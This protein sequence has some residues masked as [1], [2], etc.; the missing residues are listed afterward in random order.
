MVEAVIWKLE[1]IF[2][3]VS[4]DRH[5]AAGKVLSYLQS[6]PA[7]PFVDEA[8]RLLFLKGTDSHDYKYSSA[9]LEDYLGLSQEWRDRYLAAS[10]F[11]LRGSGTRDNDLVQRVRAA[12]HS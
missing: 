1:D 11:N 6:S 10:V 5:A 4:R 9:V 8:R 12:L 7:E 2:A 3:D